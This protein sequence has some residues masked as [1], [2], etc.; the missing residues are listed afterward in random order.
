MAMRKDVDSMV[1]DFDGPQD[2]G[3]HDS[4][5]SS[6]YL[7]GMF[8]VAAPGIRDSGFE[9]TV[10]YVTKHGARGARGLV[11]NKI[12]PLLEAS[13]LFDQLKIE[14]HQ[15]VPYPAVY[16][17]GPVETGRGYVLHGDD[18]S[19]G[20][21]RYDSE[22]GIA[23][24]STLDVLEA[25]AAGNGPVRALIVLGHASWAPHQLEN[26]L[27][28]HAWLI[29]RTDAALIFDTPAADRWTLALRLLG[30]RPGFVSET[31]GSA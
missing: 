16:H 30:V 5:L 1:S 20:D 14:V 24:T 26:E 8:L 11:V 13:M 29:C 27:A 7:Q 21:T 15:D 17:G 28:Q 12:N 31:A 22:T 3:R 25:V 23:V 19:G 9:K 6:G 2:A 10:I 4:D 18:F